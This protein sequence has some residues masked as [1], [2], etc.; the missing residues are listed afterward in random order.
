MFVMK[1]CGIRVTVAVLA[2]T[3]GLLCHVARKTLAQKSYP[4]KGSQEASNLSSNFLPYTEPYVSNG[5]ERLYFRLSDGAFVSFGCADRSDAEIA[6]RIVRSQSPLSKQKTTVFSD[7]GSSIGERVVWA[8]NEV[9]ARAG[10]WWNEGSHLFHISGTSLREVLAFETSNIWKSESCMDFTKLD[11][12]P[13][14]R[15]ERTRR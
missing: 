10:I 15:L 6:L 2:F 14:K 1:Q 12:P 7:Q 11:Q 3:L 4:S 13:N 5:M 9:P 8:T